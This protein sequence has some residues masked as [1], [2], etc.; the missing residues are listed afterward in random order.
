LINL[1][2]QKKDRNSTENFIKL[3]SDN[4]ELWINELEEQ[5]GCDKVKLQSGQYLSR[6][7]LQ[8]LIVLKLH[9]FVHKELFILFKI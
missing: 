9:Y 6:N 1:I 4:W 2:F 8:L 7:V 5:T 3:L